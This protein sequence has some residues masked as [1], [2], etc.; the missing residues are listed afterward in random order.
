MICMARLH[1]TE[2]ATPTS[3]LR[4][5]PGSFLPLL[6]GAC[7]RTSPDEDRLNARKPATQPPIN[8]AH[9]PQFHALN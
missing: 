1:A 6:G 7:Q 2:A 8:T 3:I 5:G 9:R 4:T